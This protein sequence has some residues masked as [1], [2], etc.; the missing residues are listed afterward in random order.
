[1]AYLRTVLI[2]G[3]SGG[4]G[5]QIARHFV[6]DGYRVAL[7]ALPAAGL[8]LA[9][10]QLIA[11]FPSANVLT[12]AINLAADDASDAVYGWAIQHFGH[13]EVLVNCA[14]FGSFGFVNDT[15]M[16]R[17]ADMIKVNVLA[18]HQLTRFFLADMIERDEGH[19]INIASIAGYQPNP[20]LATYGATKSFVLNFSQAIEYELRER[21]SKV[22][23]TVV[24]PTATKNTD[25]SQAA[26]M[27]NTNT[28]DNWL[29]VTAELVA[30]DTYN[31]FKQGKVVVIPNIVFRLLHILVKRLPVAWLM[32]WARS[33]VKIVD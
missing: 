33:N 19:I 24:C 17:E 21:R 22:R 2:T 1:M 4:I 6:R 7:V 15:D 5:F 16:H 18:L 3:G 12:Y 8:E 31:G 25:F 23:I 11:E 32:R 13:V 9:K 29:A 20:F 27:A 14:G 28:F 30:R 10:Q 26:G